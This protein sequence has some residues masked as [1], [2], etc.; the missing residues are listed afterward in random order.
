MQGEL[1][2]IWSGG[3]MNSGAALRTEGAQNKEQRLF[4]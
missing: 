4:F 1:Q 3:S 2:S